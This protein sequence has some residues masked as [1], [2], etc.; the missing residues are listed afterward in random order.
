MVVASTF[1]EEGV[2]VAQIDFTLTAWHLRKRTKTRRRRSLGR[3]F[4]LKRR[5]HLGYDLLLLL[6][7]LKQRGKLKIFAYETV[8]SRDNGDDDGEKAQNEYFK[9]N[10]QLDA[11]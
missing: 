11:L 8:N 6:L 10:F 5:F 3:R 7:L 1:A 2:D 4:L 9:L